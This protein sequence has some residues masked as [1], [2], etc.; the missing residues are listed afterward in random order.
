MSTY[1]DR[2]KPDNYGIGTYLDN[3]LQKNYQI[4]TFQRGVVWDKDNVK[5]LWDSIYRFY[6]LGSILVWKTDLK[7]QN[8]REIGGHI[9]T[10]HNNRTEYQYILDGQQRTTSLLTSLYGGKIEGRGDFDPT[11]YFDLTVEDIDEIDDESYKRRFLFWSEIDDKGGTL[12]QNKG[13][14]KRYNEGLVVK[15]QGIRQDFGS[16]ERK[17]IDNGF[18]D[19]DHPYRERLRQIRE[20]L[21]NYRISFI[22]LK[23]IHVSQVCQIFQRIN[24]EGKPLSIFDIVV[25]KTFR[26][27][28]EEREGFY[29][30]ELIDDFRNDT[31][32]Y[33]KDLDDLTYLQM[34]SVLINQHVPDSRIHNITDRYLNDIKASQIEETWTQ[35]TIAFLKTFDFFENHLHIKGPQLVPYRYFYMTLVNYFYNNP[36][37]NYDYLKKY[38]WYFSF[39]NEDLLSNTTHLW[40]HVELLTKE[41]NGKSPEFDRFLID[42]NHLRTASYSS[43][44]RLS[45]AILCMFANEEPRDWSYT[46][47]RVLSDVYYLLTDKPNLHHVFPLN[48][49]ANNPGENR[50][51][52]NSLMNI[53]YLTQITNLEI[54]D[55][56]PIVY[57][58][59]Y[60]KTGFEEILSSHL[61]PTEILEW[62]RMDEMP[63]NSLDVFIE[64]RIDIL[65]DV[66]RKILGGIT[67]DVIDTKEGEESLLT[68]TTPDG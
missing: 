24:Q 2:I 55:N 29:L 30:R 9:I 61:I 63:A 33:F 40:S 60:D 7:L 31:E 67:V 39:H 49:I 46:D 41:K 21:D 51:D 35:A 36:N 42:K 45:R 54:S 25:A 44:G 37:P 18:D 56:N 65:L 34:L 10:D 27:E 20:V 6:P 14:I 43:R 48:Y 12:L 11:L 26:T 8:H 13:R 28:T 22:E 17:L 23:G 52:S 4:P 53:A 47:R 19:Y 16:L 58:K 62:S 50:L 57:L 32:G 3:L 59:D 15:L 68:P 38:F 1:T 66:L 64:K 5:K